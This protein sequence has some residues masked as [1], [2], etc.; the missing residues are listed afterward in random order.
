M[1]VAV[2]GAGLAGLSAA[3]ELRRAGAEVVVLEA[4]DRVGG[5]VWS[6]RLGNGALVEM[7]AEFL[8][9]GNTAMRGLAE[10]FGLGLWDKGMRYGRRDPRGVQ[11]SPEELTAAVEAV[12]RALERRPRGVSARQLLDGLDIAAGAREALLARAEISSA[13][14]ADE[15]AARDLGGI[16][17]IDDDPAPSIA[18][19]NQRVPL[20]LAASLGA[21]VRLRSQV[22]RV[23]WNDSGVRVRAAGV[24]VEADACVVAVP[25]GVT[26]RIRFEPALP[27]ALGAALRAIRYGHAAKLFVPLRGPA[28]PSAVMSVPERYWT[29]TATGDEDAVQPV[30]SAFAG[31]PGALQGLRVDAG[32][33]R[34][35][36]SVERLRGD[37]PLQRAGALL[38]TWADDPWAGAAYSTSPPRDTS[39]ALERGVGPLVFCGEHAGGK[40][41]ALMEG[42]VRSG[43]RAAAAVVE[44]TSA[45]QS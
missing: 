1:R 30:L 12:G 33:E 7:G 5:R 35:L 13:N 18:G 29:W 19:G 28:G 40:F 25:A 11:V 22:E 44:R 34:W 16:A 27:S 15:V 37:L 20:A 4:R 2:A 9:P 23:T 42:A 43:R 45:A 26:G 6:R 21:A 3:D 39:D 10:R 17:H 32:P 14:S 8:L 31:S 24:E 36:D 38:S 41:A